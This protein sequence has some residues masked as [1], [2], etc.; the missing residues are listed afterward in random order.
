[1]SLLAQLENILSLTYY[2]SLIPG[3]F[4]ISLLKPISVQYPTS[5]RSF[6]PRFSTLGLLLDRSSVSPTRTSRGGYY[7]PGIIPLCIS[8]YLV[9]ILII[10]WTLWN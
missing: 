8:A 5:H 4:L 3:L 7:P 1:M 2:P 6:D 10:K 9:S